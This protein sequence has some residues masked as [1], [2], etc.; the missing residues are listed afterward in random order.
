MKLRQRLLLSFIGVAIVVTTIFGT[1]A[2]YITINYS[3]EEKIHL[4]QFIAQKNASDLS[5]L[6]K[7]TTNKNLIHPFSNHNFND[8]F[9]YVLLNENNKPLARTSATS[10][11]DLKHPLS[12][13]IGRAH[14]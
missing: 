10:L 6:T 13:Q 5:A 12:Q 7:N 8:I 1:V 9:S 3:N 11:L 4:L 2:Y 14:V